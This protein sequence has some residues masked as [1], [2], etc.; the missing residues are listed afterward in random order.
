MEVVSRRFESFG[1]PL[2]IDPCVIPED[3]TTLFVCSGMQRVR[4]RFHPPDGGVYGSL[5][6]CIRTNDLDLVGDG[7]HLTHF[8]MLGNF[9]FGGPPYELSVD[10]WHS[11]LTDLGVPISTVHCHPSRPDLSDLWVRRGYRVMPDE[12]CVWSDGVIGGHCCE[13]YVGGLEIGNL[14]NPLGHSTD[15]GF[16]WE[17][18]VQVIEGKRRVDQTSLFRQDCHPVVAD[19]ERTLE[20]LRH[21]GIR[22]GNKGREYVC[23]RLLRRLLRHVTGAMRFGFDGWVEEERTLLE[24]RLREGRRAWRRHRNKPPSWWWE[25]FGI[26]PE[27]LP[28][29]AGGPDGGW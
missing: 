1:F 2:V 22:P 29:L 3:D 21:N 6:S 15:V 14:V 7:S 9:S 26:L 23:R 20:V 8:Q 5:Q 25:T 16:G 18:L 24:C 19:H 11:I 28:L 12:E 4:R 13:L 10:L 17:R 27:E